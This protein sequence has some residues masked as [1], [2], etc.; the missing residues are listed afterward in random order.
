[1][2]T[3]WRVRILKRLVF[4][5]EIPRWHRAW[6]QKLKKDDDSFFTTLLDESRART[7]P[8]ESHYLEPEG[9]NSCPGPTSHCPKSS[10]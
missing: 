5:R 8:H 3:T 1:M 9:E 2:L 10:G 7:R 4:I 6:K